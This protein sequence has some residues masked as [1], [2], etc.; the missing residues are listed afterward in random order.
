MQMTALHKTPEIISPMVYGWLQVNNELISL[1]FASEMIL[2]CWISNNS[3]IRSL[4]RHMTPYTTSKL[5]QIFL[6]WERVGGCWTGKVWAGPSPRPQKFPVPKSLSANITQLFT[7]ILVQL[8]SWKVL[9]E[10]VSITKQLISKYIAFHQNYQAFE[11]A[12]IKIYR[13]S[14]STSHCVPKMCVWVHMLPE[15]IRLGRS[16]NVCHNLA[17]FLITFSS[18][19]IRNNPK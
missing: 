17:K 1:R 18:A 3:P 12:L 8:M 5:G 16:E 11:I 10:F 6:R 19:Q 9:Y 2:V 14:N 7:P 13:Y 15:M 4:S